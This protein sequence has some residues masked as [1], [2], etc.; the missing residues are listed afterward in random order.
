MNLR[1]HDRLCDHLL[2][3]APYEPVEELT[4]WDRQWGHPL[5]DEDEKH[6]PGG[7]AVTI[8]YEA[9]R[10]ELA[11]DYQRIRDHI[12]DELAEIARWIVDAALGLTDD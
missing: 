6:C 8:D 11:D 10:V 3:A 12:E 5:I 2:F 9:A 4:V 1:D 7:A